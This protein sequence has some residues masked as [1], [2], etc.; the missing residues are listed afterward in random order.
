MQAQLYNYM[1]I[2]LFRGNYVNSQ[3][4]IT[5]YMYI[6]IMVTS[7][8]WHQ[9]RTCIYKSSLQVQVHVYIDVHVQVHINVHVCT[10][11]YMHVHN[12]MH[13]YMYNVDCVTQHYSH[14]SSFIL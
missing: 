7:K 5:L 14:T 12:Y 9:S 3:D 6:I 13:M 10:Y 4:A 11:M 8:V 2:T 1:Y